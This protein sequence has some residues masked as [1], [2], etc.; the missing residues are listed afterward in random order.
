MN[1]VILLYADN[2]H[3]DGILIGVFTQMVH[4]MTYC[5]L[6]HP[7][8]KSVGSE[9]EFRFNANDGVYTQYHAKRVRLNTAIKT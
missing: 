8:G 6:K 4:I 5:M 1:D 3:V 2:H 9:D 7:D